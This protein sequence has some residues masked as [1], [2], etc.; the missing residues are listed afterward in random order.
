METIRFGTTIWD[1]DK[2]IYSG[3]L[4]LLALALADNTLYGFSSPEEVFEQRIPERQDEL[5]LRWNEDA[6]N[7]YIVRKVTAAGVSEDSLMKEM[8]AADFRKI[9]VN[10]Y[11]FVT[12]TV[13]AMRRAL[14]GA[15]K[16]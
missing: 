15:V 1:C 13:H 14:E 10:I 16:S 6:K 4:F 2:S 5:V 7:R 9:L 3:G 8:Y 12:A 11:Y